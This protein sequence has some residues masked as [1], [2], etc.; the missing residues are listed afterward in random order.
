MLFMFYTLQAKRNCALPVL[1]EFP[2]ISQFLI[3]LNCGRISMK[4]SG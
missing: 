2:H 1:R 3:W 4:V